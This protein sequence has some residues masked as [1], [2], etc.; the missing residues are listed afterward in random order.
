MTKC[1][2]CKRKIVNGI[3]LSSGAMIHESCLST[4]EEKKSNAVFLL[5]DLERELYWLRNN[6]KRKNSIGYKIKSFF[7]EPDATLFGIETRIGNVRVEIRKV[8]GSLSDIKSKLSAIYDYFLTYPP[9]WDERRSIVISN[10]GE[11]CSQC[12]SYYSLHLHHITP[13]SKGGSNENTNL[14]LLCQ[15]CHS[16]EHGGRKFS[17][18]FNNSETVFS[19]RVSKI[20]EAINTDKSLEF[21]YKKYDEKY[22]KRRIIK[23]HELIKVPHRRG[24]GSTLCVQGFC[25]L[26]QENRKFAVKRIRGLKI[27]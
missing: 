4:H 26:R 14:V 8:K 13:L 27:I 12:G 21:E 24:S 22:Y 10:D 9:D 7:S 6:L 17:G 15:E 5:Q 3:H 2:L 1:G 20:Q 11:I 25:E 16:Q 23:P 19:K 18:N